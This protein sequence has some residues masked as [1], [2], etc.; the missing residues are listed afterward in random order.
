VRRHGE[1]GACARGDQDLS[2]RTL[3]SYHGRHAAG[4]PGFAIDSRSAHADGS[5]TVGTPIERV[6]LRLAPQEEER[7]SYY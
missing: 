7:D 3:A 6:L 1:C 2:C 5:R 4:T